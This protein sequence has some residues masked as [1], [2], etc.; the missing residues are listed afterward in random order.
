MERTKFPAEQTDCQKILSKY[1]GYIPAIILP[2]KDI[3]ICKRRF[4]LP[5]TENFG[6][7]II[8]IRK[9]IQLKP[10]EAIF[11][12][13]DNKIVDMKQ[14]IEDFYSQ[15]KLNKKPENAYLYIQIIKEKTFGKSDRIYR[16]V[17]WIKALAPIWLD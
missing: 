17:P 5:K 8:N 10:S 14:N 13:I 15:Y 2:D 1:Y 11:F 9:H 7:C 6:F 12:L 4:L 16:N 3:E